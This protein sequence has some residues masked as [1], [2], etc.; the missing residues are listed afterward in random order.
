MIKLKDIVNEIVNEGGKLF[1]TRASRVST[2]E[3]NSIFETRRE[4]IRF[5]NLEIRKID[6]IQTVY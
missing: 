5:I 3:M 2:N 6:G 1:G 4:L